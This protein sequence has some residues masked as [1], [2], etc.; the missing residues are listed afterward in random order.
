MLSP[1]SHALRFSSESSGKPLSKKPLKN[2]YLQAN[3]YYIGLIHKKTRG[4]TVPRE[5][6]AVARDEAKQ[7]ERRYLTSDENKTI[8]AK[9]FETLL[10]RFSDRRR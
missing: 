3:S 6:M 5:L 9:V 1:V 4:E 7:A 2:E 10:K 8:I